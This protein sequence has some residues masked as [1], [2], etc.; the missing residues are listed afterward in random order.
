VEG[1]WRHPEIHDRIDLV[2]VSKDNFAVRE[3][4]VVGEPSPMTDIVVE[5]WPSDHRAVVIEL[6]L[7]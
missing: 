3:A 7:L 2:Y 6:D 1:L 4:G 5:P